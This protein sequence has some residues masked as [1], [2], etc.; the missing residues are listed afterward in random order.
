[1]CTSTNTCSSSTYT[2]SLEQ[3]SCAILSLFGIFGPFCGSR[4]AFPV[5]AG[6]RIGAEADEFN[7][8]GPSELALFRTG[9]GESWPGVYC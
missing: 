1:M 4:G 3:I 5:L 8:P 7:A 6:R 9:D 2:R